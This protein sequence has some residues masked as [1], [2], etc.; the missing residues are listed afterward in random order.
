MHHDTTASREASSRATL[1]APWLSIIVPTLNEAATIANTLRRLRELP[2]SE[3]E[4]IIVDGGSKDDTVSRA[5]PLASR[6]I[7]SAPGRATQMNA[8]ARASRG[9]QL[10]F[11]HADTRLPP[12]AELLIGKALSG[13]RCWGRFDVSLAGKHKLLP[14]IASAMNLRSRLSGIATGDQALF[15]TRKAFEAVG[16]FP[17][18]P[19]MEDIEMSKRLGRLSLPVCLKQ[20]VIS[21]GRR[22]DQ[23]GAWATIRLMWRLRWRYWRG[24]SAATLAK[25]YRHVR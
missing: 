23:A 1:P 24:E 17:D 22:W 16:G 10:L 14:L 20:R 12:H 7:Q 19:L 5:I 4:T 9:E 11:L 2:D 21:S 3:V 18:Q 15:M 6:L 8:G 13:S 25:E